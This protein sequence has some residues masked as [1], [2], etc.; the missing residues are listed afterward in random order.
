M[1]R[2][3]VFFAFFAVALCWFIVPNYFLPMLL[4]MSVLCWSGTTYGPVGLR[5]G[6]I[7]SCQSRI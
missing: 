6:M 1:Q 5:L 4:T 3:K 2:L 7:V